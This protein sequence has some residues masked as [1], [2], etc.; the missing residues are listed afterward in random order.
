MSHFQDLGPGKPLVPGNLDVMDIFNAEGR[1]GQELI[2]KEN[3]T[4]TKSGQPGYT[5]G[6]PKNS[7]PHPDVAP[8][9]FKGVA[10]LASTQ[11]RSFLFA[12]RLLGNQARRACRA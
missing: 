5:Q 8:P 4:E 1:A 11:K 3:Q 10:R 6:K 12:S 9:P 2:I 7:G